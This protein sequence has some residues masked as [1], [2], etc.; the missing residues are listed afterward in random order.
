MKEWGMERKG[1]D[2]HIYTPTGFY[3]QYK[4]EGIPT[5]FPFSIKPSELEAS[6]WCMTFEIDIN[7]KYGVVI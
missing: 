7:S 1:L 6:D 2:V 5:D 3:K 4:E